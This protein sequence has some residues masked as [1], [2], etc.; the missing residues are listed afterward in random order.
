MNCYPIQRIYVSENEEEASKEKML[1]PNFS[2]WL[3]S[4]YRN[5]KPTSQ[6][7]LDIM[8]KSPPRPQ[9]EFQNNSPKSDTSSS[10]Y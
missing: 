9:L 6:D 10:Q 4:M 2:K 5:G 1:Y 7:W 3:K 8:S